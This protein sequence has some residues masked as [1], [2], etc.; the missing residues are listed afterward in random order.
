MT[1]KGRTGKG[2]RQHAALVR[3]NVP[4]CEVFWRGERL[5]VLPGLFDDGV[6]RTYTGDVGEVRF[7]E[8]MKKT[9]AVERAANDLLEPLVTGEVPLDSPPALYRFQL[10]TTLMTLPTPASVRT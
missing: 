2:K 7:F 10:A 6:T 1:G 5:A 3:W 9:E 8:L 4:T